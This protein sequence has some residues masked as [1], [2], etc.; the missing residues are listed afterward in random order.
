MLV[1]NV[2]REKQ[3]KMFSIE[4]PDWGRGQG[5]L[6]L[7]SRL[8]SL[9]MEEKKILFRPTRFSLTDLE[10][11]DSIEPWKY[12][13]GFESSRGQGN[14]KRLE[15]FVREA[16]QLIKIH[17]STWD[18]MWSFLSLNEAA[19]SCGRWRA[20]RGWIC[21]NVSCSCCWTLR[22]FVFG[23]P[24]WGP[25]W[26]DSWASSWKPFDIRG[27]RWDLAMTTNGES[28]L[29]T[30]P[31]LAFGIPPL[32]PPRRCSLACPGRRWGPDRSPRSRGF[33]SWGFRLTGRGWNSYTSPTCWRVCRRPKPRGS[34][35]W[36]QSTRQILL[37]RESK[38]L[39]CKCTRR[40]EI[41]QGWVPVW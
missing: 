15:C 16:Q 17:W 36:Q 37:I 40:R 4:W 2:A 24:C 14:N 33:R 22:T 7:T 41:F 1:T 5:F 21:Q 35:G 6:L 39:R 18:S 31:N 12:R 28:F 13:I 32:S 25:C 3:T 23:I 29:A 34:S 26:W 10:R 30:C 9:I 11:L 38:D 20:C 27:T 19:K 8:L